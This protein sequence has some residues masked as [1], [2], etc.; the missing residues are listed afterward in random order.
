MLSCNWLHSKQ[1]MERHLERRWREL[2]SEE[3]QTLART[4]YLSCAVAAMVAKKSL[5]STTIVSVGSQLAAA[6]LWVVKTLMH[7]STPKEEGS[8]V[9]KWEQLIKLIGSGWAW[10]DSGF[11]SLDLDSPSGPFCRGS[12]CLF[13]RMKL[14]GCRRK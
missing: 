9:V 6:H 11:S 5:C 12:L 10:T 14:T 7:L 13:N 2:R 4:H 1:R 8:V 3:D